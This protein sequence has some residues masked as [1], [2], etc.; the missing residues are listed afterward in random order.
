MAL[1]NYASIIGAGMN[2]VPDL[3][4]QSMQDQ[5]FKMQRE[6]FDAKRAE[7]EREQREKVEGREALEQALLS[8]K[9]QDLLRIMA[10]YPAISEQVKPLWEA[11]DEKDRRTSLTQAGTIYARGQAGDYKGAAVALRARVDADRAA[12]Q[13][14]PEDEAILAGLESG[15]PVQQRA[16]MQ[17]VGVQI[18]AIDPDKFAETY[19]KLNP[20]EKIDPVQRKVDYY[21]SIGRDDLAEQILENEATDV[22]V[23]QPGAPVMTKQQA[24]A[25]ARSGSGMPSQSGGGDQSAPALGGVPA[26]GAAIEQ[27]ALAAVPGAVVTS[28]QRSA[29]HNKAVGGVA[30][31]YHLTDQARDFVPP[32]GMA[33]GALWNRLK[34][35]LPGFDVINEGDHVHVEPSGSR[36]VSPTRI[37]TKQQYDKLASGTAYIAPDGSHRVKP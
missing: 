28:R 32:Q 26:T 6:V 36:S 8:G 24:I 27:A 5:Q 11:M 31:S 7:A 21:R 19:G 20:A 10:Q 22:V 35:A 23:G 1:E 4:A 25:L 30:R 9:P 12:G 37:A 17:M 34:R 16:A 14:D 18:A 2:L 33:M 3:R 13:A 15:D 29:A